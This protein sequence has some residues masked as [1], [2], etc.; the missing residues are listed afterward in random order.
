V[1]LHTCTAVARSHCVSWAF[2][3]F[4]LQPD[5]Y[6]ADSKC[7]PSAL[8]FSDPC[9]DDVFHSQPS[10]S[11]SSQTSALPKLVEDIGGFLPQLPVT[12]S[13]ELVLPKPVEDIGVFLPQPSVSSSYALPQPVEDIGV[14]QAQ[15]CALPKPVEDISGVCQPQISELSSQVFAFPQPVEEMS[16]LE[17][18]PSVSSSQPLA[19]P[20]PV[21]D[22]SICRSQLTESSPQAPD[23]PQPVVDI[24][25]ETSSLHPAASDAV[26]KGLPSV[27]QSEQSCNNVCQSQLS[28]SATGAL[29]PEVDTSE[30]C[31]K[32]S[33]VIAGHKRVGD[34]QGDVETD[35]SDEP[36]TVIVNPAHENEDASASCQHHLDCASADDDRNDVHSSSNTDNTQQ[37]L[38]ADLFMCCSDDNVPAS[39]SVH[40]LPNHEQTDS[41]AESSCP[42]SQ[43]ETGMI[44]DDASAAVHVRIQKSA[45]G[46]HFCF[47]IY[48]ICCAVCIASRFCSY[49]LCK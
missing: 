38:P 31:L 16:I 19:L 2:L 12:M 49:F 13:Q 23:L 18:Q 28:E 24:G 10:V 1:G 36:S 46:M 44:S 15:A 40:D 4:L 7:L 27:S 34:V 9:S 20:Q 45:N 39:E 32:S 43:S 14:F 22:V 37:S 8:T 5:G 30:A 11:S 3:L 26:S 21:E 33:P 42:G 29:Q 6:D 17:S 47:V 35:R 25:T 48:Y 41:A